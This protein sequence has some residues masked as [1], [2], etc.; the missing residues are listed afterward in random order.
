MNM[1]YLS[2]KNGIS[3]SDRAFMVMNA[4][5]EAKRPVQEFKNAYARYTSEHGNFK[6]MQNN[7]N[8]DHREG[9]SRARKR[10]TRRR[11]RRSKK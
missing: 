3:S 6:T 11:T 5:K 8:N 4:L 10:K 9:G 7:A 2:H 1:G